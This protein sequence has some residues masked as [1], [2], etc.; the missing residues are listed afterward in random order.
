MT[1]RR[2]VY[3]KVFVAAFFSLSHE[4]SARRLFEGRVIGVVFTAFTAWLGAGGRDAH[5]SR[6]KK[7]GDASQSITNKL[8]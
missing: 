6:Q 4:R 5:A 8:T 1:V 3:L 7:V 2:W